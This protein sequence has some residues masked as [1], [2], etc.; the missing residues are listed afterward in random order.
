[1]SRKRQK[2]RAPKPRSQPRPQTR[3]QPRAQGW[4]WLARILI[5][6][7]IAGSIYLSWAALAGERLPGCGPESGCDEVLSSRWAR[8]FGIPVAF[9]ALLVYGALA[10]TAGGARAGSSMALQRVVR[11]VTLFAAGLTLFAAAWFVGLQL[12]A[13]GSFCV[14]CMTVHAC[15]SAAALLIL[16]K[17]AWVRP[18]GRGAH[19]RD[20]VLLSRPA[21]AGVMVWA[22]LAIALLGLAQSLSQPP[23]F[24]SRGMPGGV[25]LGSVPDQVGGVSDQGGSDE[26]QPGMGGTRGR[27]LRLHSGAF[28]F[29]LDQVPYSGEVTA[30]HVVVNLFD[31]TCRHCRVLH[32]FLN[33]TRRTFSNQLAI[34]SL[35]VPLDPGCNGLVT[36]HLPDHTNACVYARIGLAVW[37]ADR[38]H[39]ET[40]E[41]WM[42]TPPRPPTPEA[43][44]EYA[45]GLVGADAFSRATNDPWIAQQ[46]EQS[47]RLFATNYQQSRISRL[48]QLVIG[49]NI[50]VGDFRRVDA[51]YQLL[52]TQLNLV[53]PQRVGP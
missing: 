1:V 20:V 22:L 11:A 34:V 13:V 24:V 23:A 42:F 31:Y 28:E 38:R 3:S 8:L 9:G 27:I 6:A 30:P 16:F 10:M 52:S 4:L 53:V 25:E 51:L 50:V 29:D 44:R 49:T 32:G 41:G 12:F 43:A 46:L 21:A 5:A 39:M 45:I 18:R 26:M 48:P 33:E 47:T 36:R 19:T 14:Y 40:F 37:R 15:G 7:A 17:T 35:P 2:S